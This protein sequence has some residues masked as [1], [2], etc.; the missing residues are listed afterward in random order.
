MKAKAEMLKGKLQEWRSWMSDKDPHSITQQIYT[1]IWDDAVYRI[2][3]ECRRL[4][5]PAKEGGVQL[6]GMVHKFIDRSHFRLQPLAIRK[7]IDTRSDVVSLG[8]LLHD[9]KENAHLLTRG[10]FFEAE[11]LLYDIAAAR[12]YEEQERRR[13]AREARERGQL[14][15]RLHSNIAGVAC[16]G[17]RAHAD[18]DRFCRTEPDARRESDSLDPAFIE[19]LSKRL[20]VCTG[21]RNY[22]NKIV[23]HAADPASLSQLSD[24]DRS[25][26]L[27]RIEEC[28]KAICG[29][30]SFV[31]IHLL[32][33]PHLLD[34]AIPQSDLFAY[35]EKPWVRQQDISH[36]QEYWH[37]IGRETHEWG[38]P[39]WPGGW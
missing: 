22:V 39:E 12:E 3:N 26:S 15:Y 4:A 34:L 2:I 29:V 16:D 37:R 11:G 1:V 32:R 13:A 31:S 21:V 9:I 35:I 7:L 27:A 38:T 23:A 25:L 20:E 19:A 30:A 5:P 36:L 6:N 24:E 28:H 14:A 33:R 17:K 18:F 8:R 10:A